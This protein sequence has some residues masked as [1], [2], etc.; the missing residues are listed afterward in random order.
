LRT[1][2]ENRVLKRILGPT[3]DEIIGGWRKLHCE[4]LYNLFSLP[5]IIGTS[6]QNE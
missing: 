4:K 5:N 2:F 6:S 1:K 3:R